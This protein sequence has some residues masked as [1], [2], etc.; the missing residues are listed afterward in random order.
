MEEKCKDQSFLLMNYTIT[1]CKAIVYFAFKNIAVIRDSL[2]HV[3]NHVN[4][5]ICKIQCRAMKA[6]LTRQIYLITYSCVHAR[7]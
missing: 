6:K 1:L 2:D 3:D 4:Y 7:L 5:L